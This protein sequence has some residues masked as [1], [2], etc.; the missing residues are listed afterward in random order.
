VKIVIAPQYREDYAYWSE[1]DPKKLRK[2]DR[3]FTAV[4]ADPFKG[5]GKPEPLRFQYAGCWS[6]RITYEHRIVY[7][8]QSD[9]ITFLSCR[10]HYG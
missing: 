6:R 9:T 3:L 7:S 1:R 5:I 8:I 10:G 2:I 4:C